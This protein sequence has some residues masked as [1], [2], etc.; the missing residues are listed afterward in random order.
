MCIQSCLCVC[1]CVCFLI[2]AINSG[3]R[4]GAHCAV[5]DPWKAIG[6]CT[7]TFCIYFKKKFGVLY[8]FCAACVLIARFM[9]GVSACFI[10]T[11]RKQ[12][13]SIIMKISEEKSST[14]AVSIVRP[15]TCVKWFDLCFGWLGNSN[16]TKRDETKRSNSS[17][18][19]NDN[20]RKMRT[21]MIRGRRKKN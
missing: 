10:I 11:N 6:L 1:V 16:E 5:P 12:W 4:T 20:N 18:S 8:A 9:F 14:L 2:I 19:I 13:N 3:S 17:S 7:S 15:H 21:Q